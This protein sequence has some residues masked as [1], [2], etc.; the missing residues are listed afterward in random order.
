VSSSRTALIQ[1]WFLS[2]GGSEQVAVELAQLLPG[3]DVFTTFLDPEYVPQL[4]GH[5]TTTWPLHRFSSM[6]RRYRSLLPLYPVWF[7][8]LDLRQYDLVI[9]SSSAFAKAV[10][11]RDGAQHLAY[12]HAPMR[13]AW[14]LGGYLGGSSFSLSS[15]IAARTIRPALRRWD[16]RTA[17]RPEVLIANSKAVRDRIRRFWNRDARVIHPPVTLDDIEVGRSDD[18]YLL[19]VARLVAYRRVDLI[20]RAATQV[21]RDLIVVGEGPELSRLRGLAGPTVTLLGRL[22]RPEVVRLLQGCHAYVVP[23]E[24]DFGIAPVEAMAAGKPV[25]A[26]R[27][28]G[29][30]E[31]VREGTTG[32][33]FEHQ[34]VDAVLE[35]IE[36][37]DAMSFDPDKI[38]SHAE[39]FSAPA[40]RRGMTN[41]FAEL[42]IEPSLYRST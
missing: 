6:R 20:V 19:T 27:A 30:T 37:A 38:R 15:R 23:G 12:I 1:D 32:V 25:I 41:L 5:A 34:T 42:G 9:S 17:G 2:P 11:T 31:T 21:G 16:R 7:E 22:E 4:S 13:Y 10:K 29:A 36:R 39:Q 35:A 14:D 33:F 28:G 18:G 26:F 3:S 24:E 40:F 8:R